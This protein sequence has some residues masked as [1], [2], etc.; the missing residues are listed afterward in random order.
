MYPFGSFHFAS[1]IGK[2]KET[3]NVGTLGTNRYSNVNVN[4]TDT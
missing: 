1:F 3:W 4:K 2:L